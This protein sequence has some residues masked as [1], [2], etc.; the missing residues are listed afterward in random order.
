MAGPRRVADRRPAGTVA[1][2]ESDLRASLGEALHALVDTSANRTTIELSGPRARDILESGCSIDLAPRS[3]APRPLRA[4]APRP[5]QR[6][7]LAAGRRP[8]LPL[9]VRPSFAPY[10]AAWLADAADRG[11]VQAG[12]HK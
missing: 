12:V 8:D 6:D 1:A 2:I 4:D 5:R 11:S 10:L 3:F 7:P 9:L